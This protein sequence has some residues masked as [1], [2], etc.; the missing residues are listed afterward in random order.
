MAVAYEDLNGKRLPETLI[1]LWYGENQR[2]QQ[3]QWDQGHQRNDDEEAG[4]SAA[5]SY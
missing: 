3:K 1:D 5:E 4:D 2:N